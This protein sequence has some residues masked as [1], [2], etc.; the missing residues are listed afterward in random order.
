MAMQFEAEAIIAGVTFYNGVIDGK[1]LDSGAFF[2]NEELDRSNENANGTRTTE[3]SAV[4]SEV[5]KRIIKNTFPCRMKLTYERKV[6][7]GSEKLIIID[8]KP[9]SIKPQPQA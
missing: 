7:K 4:N 1:T 5:V 6:T 8:A 3:N 2:I 9:V